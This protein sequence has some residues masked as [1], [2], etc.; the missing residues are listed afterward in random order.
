MSNETKTAIQQAEKQ[1]DQERKAQLQ[2][3]V[4]EYLKQEL[5]SIDSIDNQVR[6]LTTQKKAHEENI[7]N[8]K[9]GN[10]GAIEKRRLAFPS[11][12]TLTFSQQFPRIWNTT[13]PNFYNTFVAGISYTTVSGKTYIF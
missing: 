10:L 5:D 11:T 12:A 13:G 3:E 6:E 1:L 4:Y 9:Q 7:K 2:R 8:I